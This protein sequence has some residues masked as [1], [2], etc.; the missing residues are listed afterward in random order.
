MIFAPVALICRR[1]PGIAIALVWGTEIYALV[2]RAIR[3][4][5][6]GAAMRL[7]DQARK[8][9]RLIR[10]GAADEL[11]EADIERPRSAGYPGNGTQLG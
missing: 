4:A 1:K 6:E 3:A 2:P 5:T 11:A 7:R 10:S 9:A 8:Q